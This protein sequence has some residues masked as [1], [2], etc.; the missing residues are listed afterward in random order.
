MERRCWRYIGNGDIENVYK[1][2]VTG[3]EEKAGEG[4]MKYSREEQQ[5]VGEEAEQE[6]QQESEDGDALLGRSSG[7]KVNGD[8]EVTRNVKSR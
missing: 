3:G 7:R 4:G 8:G 5:V 1:S 6:R 2:V